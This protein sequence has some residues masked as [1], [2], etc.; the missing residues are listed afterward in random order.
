MA[1][2]PPEMDQDKQ[3]KMLELFV[4]YRDE[5]LKLQQQGEAPPNPLEAE[6]KRNTDNYDLFAHIL[7]E[8]YGDVATVV[9]GHHIMVIRKGSPVPIEIASADT[10]IFDH[11]VAK[12]IWKDGYL[13]VLGKLAHEPIS[14]RDV[15]LRQLYY[16]R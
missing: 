16:A 11:D 8:V 14:T 10:L 6:T 15:L 12:K 9:A 13:D 3:Q 2:R 1:E 5:Q 7:E 4:E